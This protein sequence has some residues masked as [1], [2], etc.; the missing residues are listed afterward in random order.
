[1]APRLHL[2]LPK[3]AKQL[4]HV[5]YLLS[6]TSLSSGK[7]ESKKCPDNPLNPVQK[8]DYST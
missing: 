3:A 1:M 4:L 6:D 7:R 5:T 8:A 2:L